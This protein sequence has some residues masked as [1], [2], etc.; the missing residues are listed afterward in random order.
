[1]RISD[2]S[3]DVCSSDLSTTTSTV[4]RTIPASATAGAIRAARA[5]PS[6]HGSPGRGAG[7]PAGAQQLLLRAALPLADQQAGAAAG[8][9]LSGA[10]HP[11]QPFPRGRCREAVPALGELARAGPHVE[12]RPVPDDW[13]PRGI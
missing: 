7:R 3:S 11:L 10:H 1:M 13:V 9:T 4:S 5:E 2:W 6:H 8:P 12:R